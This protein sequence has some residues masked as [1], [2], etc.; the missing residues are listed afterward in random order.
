MKSGQLQCN[1]RFHFLEQSAKVA[2]ETNELTYDDDDA[3]TKQNINT[4][5]CRYR[6]V[7]DLYGKSDA[8]KHSVIFVK[9]S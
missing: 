9:T 4:D 5:L 1:L 2:V 8:M 6:R 7:F 3:H